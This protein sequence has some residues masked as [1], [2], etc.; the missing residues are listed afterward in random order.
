MPPRPWGGGNPVAARGRFRVLCAAGG[1]TELRETPDN[2]GEAGDELDH[3]WIFPATTTPG[4]VTLFDGATPAW[5]WPAGI[6]LND[7]RPVFV[8]LNWRSLE[9]AWSVTC[10]ANVSATGTGAFS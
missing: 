5:V 2:P 8:P 6:I 3:L 10:G 4:A 1:N 7:A 9:G